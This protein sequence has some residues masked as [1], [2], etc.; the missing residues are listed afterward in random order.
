[1]RAKSSIDGGVLHGLAG[2]HELRNAV[3][4]RSRENWPMVVSVIASPGA[5][6]A[7]IVAAVDQAGHAV[8]QDAIAFATGAISKMM[9]QR[10]P[11]LYSV[12][13]LCAITTLPSLRVAAGGDEGAA[14]LGDRLANRCSCA[15]CRT[16]WCNTATAPARRSS[17]P[18]PKDPAPRP[19]PSGLR[20]CPSA[21][22]DIA[23]PTC[24]H[25][26]FSAAVRKN[27]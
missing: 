13:L 27:A 9:F 3:A 17:P 24:G 7:E 8:H 10:E 1:M 12:Q 21:P 2:A 11:S 6:D 23:A 22:R 19:W 14:M 20:R 16:S 26:T 5:V 25:R 4:D 15:P 18:R